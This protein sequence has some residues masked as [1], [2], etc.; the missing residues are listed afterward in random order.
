MTASFRPL[1]AADA[2]W[3]ASLHARCFPREG[4]RETSWR[5]LLAQPGVGGTVAMVADAPAG[6]VLWRIAADEAEI[7]TI[8]VVPEQRRSGLG[9][10]LLEHAL[11][12][13]PPAVATMFLEVAA[14]NLAARGLYAGRGFVAAGIRKGYYR[15]GRDTMDGLLMR[16]D[17]ATSSPWGKS[18]SKHQRHRR[19]TA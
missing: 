1:A 16:I 2:R 6:V 18:G 4:W 13:L 3:V 14:D 19:G 5:E 7:L 12:R 17:R 8:G 11:G 9:R 15:R 10:L